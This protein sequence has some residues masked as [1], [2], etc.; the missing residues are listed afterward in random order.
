MVKGEAQARPDDGAPRKAP[1]A[2]VE[3]F[4]QVSLHVVLLAAPVPRQ[5]SLVEEVVRDPASRVALGLP[6]GAAGAS[7][8][9]AAVGKAHDEAVADAVA[10]VRARGVEDRAVV[11][12]HIAQ[13][14][15]VVLRLPRGEVPC[16][17]PAPHGCNQALHMGGAAVRAEHVLQSAH[18]PAHWR[19]RDPGMHRAQLR[20][21]LRQADGLVV[22]VP[23]GILVAGVLREPSGH[24]QAQ[25]RGVRQLRCGAPERVA[26]AGDEIGN[27]LAELVHRK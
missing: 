14:E 4:R 25:R 18:V 9:A 21:R 6:A 5:P 11:P 12:S 24:Q 16:D 26:W 15:G 13:L 8:R 17:L 27:H 20:V 23:V 7:A 2:N 22:A 3:G 19:Q 10:G 1:G